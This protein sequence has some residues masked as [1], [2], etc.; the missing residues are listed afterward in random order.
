M[1]QM[2]EITLLQ[3]SIQGIADEISGFL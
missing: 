3:E 1:N 2:F